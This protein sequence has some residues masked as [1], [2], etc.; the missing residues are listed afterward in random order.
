ML[1]F[2]EK[3]IDMPVMS[4]QTSQ[5]LGRTEAAIIDPAQLHII[6]FYV[7]GPSLDFSPALIRTEEIREVGAMGA[8]IDSSDELTRPEDLV[9]MKDI[10]D[11]DFQ[12]EGMHVIDD[13]KQ[14]LGKV[15]RYT[16]DPRTFVIHQLHVKRP[17]LKSFKD[18][19]LL[20]SRRQIVAISKDTITV[21]SPDL[22]MSDQIP[23]KALSRSFQQARPKAETI[24]PK[25]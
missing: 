8:I 24:T 7:Q 18:S 4:L 12:L 16:I 17:L 23:A 20:I 22:K 13:H 3:L 6:A 2:S 5:E 1:V 25:N 9:T 14:K 10:I 21:K 15:S 19:D 11:L